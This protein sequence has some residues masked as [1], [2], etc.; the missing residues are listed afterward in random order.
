[1]KDR[2]HKD[3]IEKAMNGH[4]LAQGTLTAKYHRART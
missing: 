1:M 2:P 4:V 3:D